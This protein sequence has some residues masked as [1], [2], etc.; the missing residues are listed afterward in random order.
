MK[1][2]TKTTNTVLATTIKFVIKI[3]KQLK[4]KSDSYFWSPT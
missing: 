3:K 1:Q 4:Q 2:T